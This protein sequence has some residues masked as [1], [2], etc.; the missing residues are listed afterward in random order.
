VLPILAAAVAPAVRRFVVHVTPEMIRHSRILDVLYFVGFVYG[1][2]VLLIILRSGISVRLR[3]LAGRVT[4]N[5]FLVAALFYALVSLVITA[6]EFPLALYRGFIL[7]HQFDLT[8]Q[9]L[10]SWLGDFAKAVGVNIII[11]APIAGV[12]L[13]IMRHFRRWWVALWLGS[14]PLIVL[15]V[16]LEPLIIDPLFNKFEPLR[17]PILRRDLL[18]EA[19]RAGIEG[20]RVYQVNASKQ[21][22]TM[23]AYMTG[24]GPSKRIVLYDTLLQKMDHDEIIATMGHEMGHYVLHHLWKG[25]AFAVAVSF[26][27]FLIAQW[28][29]ERGLPWWGFTDRADPAALPWLLLV[30]AVI[31]FA[32]SPVDSGFS[33]HVEHEADR[34]GLELTHLN[35]ASASSMVKFT[36]D[37]KQDPNPPAFIEW[38]RYSHPSAQKRID[39][40][41]K[42]RPWEHIRVR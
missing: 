24:L 13:M 21:T 10:L 6:M 23:N 17:D 19:A 41:L 40:A 37:A 4:R 16:V 32:L 26:F 1:V 9:S 22:K 35:E 29:Y 15:G 2:A 27:G 20:S 39:F 5:R 38:W 30:A 11:L 3:D 25:I 34:F 33:R 14:I 18:A 36:E 7:P 28:I 42:Y 12:T 31:T 8:D